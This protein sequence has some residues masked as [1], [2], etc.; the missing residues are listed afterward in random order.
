M[1]GAGR[2]MKEGEEDGGGGGRGREGEE[3]REE[4]EVERGREDG[5]WRGSEGRSISQRLPFLCYTLHIC[6]FISRTCDQSLSRAYKPRITPQIALS[7]ALNQKSLHK[8]TR[9]ALTLLLGHGLWAQV[10]RLVGGGSSSE[11][12]GD[13]VIQEGERGVHLRSVGSKISVT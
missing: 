10:G 9:Q 6:Y 5:R 13:E 11:G 4:E 12:L 1:G 7:C 8:K 3:G 2:K